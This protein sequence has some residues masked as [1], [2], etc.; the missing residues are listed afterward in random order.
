MFD[1]IHFKKDF[2]PLWNAN[3]WGIAST[4]PFILVCNL[5]VCKYKTAYNSSYNSA[6]CVT[7]LYMHP[8][9]QFKIIRVL[10]L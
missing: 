3:S 9:Q 5:Y 7:F 8:H 4:I 6:L 2:T 1:M 10:M